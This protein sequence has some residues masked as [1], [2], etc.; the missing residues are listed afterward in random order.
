[1][2]LRFFRG[3]V[4]DKV[5]IG[6]NDTGP[7]SPCLTVTEVQ[8]QLNLAALLHRQLQLSALIL[9]D[10]KLTAPVL[11]PHGTAR[12]LELDDINVRL[13]FQTNDMWTL[14]H[15]SAVFAGTQISV[16]SQ[17]AHASE[18]SA[19]WEFFRQKKPGRGRCLAAKS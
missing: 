9:N 7:T 11:P 15:F 5:R 19:T 16:S 2:R 14:D 3:I 10:G 13:Q 17:I 4:A 18:L 8:L 6:L 1:M 12:Q